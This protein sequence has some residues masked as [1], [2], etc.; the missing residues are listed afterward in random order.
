MSRNPSCSIT[1]SSL[2]EAV[3]EAVPGLDLKQASAVVNSI[4][5]TI[6]LGLA[7]GDEVLISGFGKFVV[8]EKRARPGRNPRTGQS[9]N[10]EARKVTKFRPS[11]V[12]KNVLNERIA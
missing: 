9:V 12:L 2:A 5:D 11:D 10:I 1:K 4:V 8:L 7:K 3:S 6:K